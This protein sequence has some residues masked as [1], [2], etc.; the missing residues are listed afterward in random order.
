MGRTRVSQMPL[1]MVKQKNPCMVLWQTWDVFWQRTSISG[2][3]NAG[4]ATSVF[5]RTC[6]MMLFTFFSIL[7]IYGLYNV[8]TDYIKYPVT[9]SVT[10]K[11]QNQVFKFGISYLVL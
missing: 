6:W 9:T 1:E 8:I 11:H 4:I 7:T 3:S 5:R 2:V 10:V